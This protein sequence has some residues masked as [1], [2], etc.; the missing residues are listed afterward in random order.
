MAS[1]TSAKKLREESTCSICLELMTEPVS[2]DCGHSFCFVCLVDL[3]ESQS[4]GTP[5]HCPLCRTPFERGNYRPN[6][7]LKNLIET[8][9][10]IECE[11]TCEEHGQQLHLFCEDD[12]QLIC[13]RCEWSPQHR[14]HTIAL[15]EDVC[16]GYQEKLQETVTTLQTLKKQC[17]SLKV[18]TQKQITEWEEKV[19]LQ[20]RTIRSDF[21]N[22][23]AFL[24]EEE[25][26]YFWKLQKEKEDTLSSLQQSKDKLERQSQ[27]LGNCILE[28]QKKCQGSSQDLL[29]NVRATLSRSLS[30]KL[31]LPEPV[32]LDVHTVCDVSELYFD[33]KEMSKSYRG[34]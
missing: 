19:E 12:D 5:I 16:Q 3:I 8:I 9:K 18:F 22:L 7:H 4:F 23:H 29:Q 30:M 33:V 20:K 21:N 32:S 27:E 2:I 26:Y 31:E 24:F 15:L 28:L 1:G 14:G 25:K 13:W 11:R 34:M 6:K 10:E 17:E